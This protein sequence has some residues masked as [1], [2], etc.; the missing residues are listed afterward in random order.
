MPA[1]GRLI[2]PRT[3]AVI[4]GKPASR[5]VEQCRRIGFEGDIWRVH[6]TAAFRTIADLPEAPDAAFVAVNRHL[7]IEI[8]GELAER[9]AGGAVCYASGFAEA[10]EEGAALQQALVEAAGAMPFFGPNCYGF[11]NYLDGVA[12]WPD[13]HGGQ[14]VERGVALVTQ[15]GN[16]GLNLTM[17]R[18]ALPVAALITLGNQAT[19]G[20]SATIEAL[21]EDPRVTAIGLHIE[22]IDDAVAFAAA[23]AK[24]R[25]RNLPVVALK[26]GRS[27]T[28]SALTIS[29][30]AS[31]AGAD[32]V[33][34]AYFR[35]AGV[36]RVGSIEVLLETLKILHITGPLSGRSICSMSCS[37]GEAALIADAAEDHDVLFAPLEPEAHAAVART[38]PPLVTISNPL[39]Y[40]TFSWADEPALTRTFTAMLG[41]GFD[42]SLLLLDLPR[43]DR[44]DPA[45]WQV[46]R[47]ALAAAARA[48]GAKVAIVATLPETLNEA[49]AATIAADG[50]VPLMG[51]DDA[52]AAIAAAADVGSVRP[53]P[54]LPPTAAT[55]VART[56]SE[57]DGKTLLSSA[58]V[59]VPTGRLV[60]TAEEAWSAAQSIGVPVVLK[61]TGTAIAHKS[62]LGAVRLGLEDAASVI[63]AAGALLE[64]SG[65]II[66][67][68]MVTDAVAELIVGIARDPVFGLH[69]LLGSG[70]VLVELVADRE[71][72]MLPAS[73][74]DIRA[75]LG[76]LR[77]AKLIAGYRGK[78]GGDFEGAVAAIAAIQNFASARGSSLFELDVNPLM[79]RPAGKG[80]VAADVLMRLTDA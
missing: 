42:L 11:L 62:E 70:G 76:R 18:R 57:W 74:D 72:L 5:V 38:L 47:K 8:A 77:V 26:T 51:I 69:L 63:S 53:T 16:I 21:A 32:A 31:L 61:A 7:T 15:S 23:V 52:L 27:A 40:H 4:G 46:S 35:A 14:P 19:V 67:E 24:A 80:A 71:I 3:I 10:G 60:H 37:G 30:T 22:G 66:V 56:L 39:D 33:A 65:D 12:L 58:G 54:M 75:A 9:G 25:A 59:A 6:P 78:P 48:S 73:T 34:D 44:C 29:H 17:Q 20:L 2:H 45:D 13:Q 43:G 49:E 64:L 79:V 55:G 41:A 36:V 68:V 1:L 50:L 28:G